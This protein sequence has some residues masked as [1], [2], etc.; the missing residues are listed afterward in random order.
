MPNWGGGNKCGACRGAV[1]HAEEV[2]C[3]GKSFHKCCFLCRHSL[4]NRPQTPT[5]PNL[6]RSLSVRTNVAGVETRSMPLRRS[7]GRASRGTRTASVAQNVARAWSQ[8]LRLRET[9]RSTAK[10]VTPRTSGPKAS[11]TA[12]GAGALV[13]AQ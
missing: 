1:Y 12:K 10:R 2:Q 6:P 5:R 13:H 7:W 3:D 11:V 8:P 9:E 4:T